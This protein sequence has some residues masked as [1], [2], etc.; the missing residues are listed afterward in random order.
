MGIQNGILDKEKEYLKY[1][2]QK[3]VDGIVLASTTLAME[4]LKELTNHRAP[5]IVLDREIGDS[6]I[7]RIRI[8]DYKGGY[9]ATEHLIKTGYRRLVH[10]AGPEGI[11]SA[12]DRKKGFLDCIRDYDL[13]QERYTI[14]QG[15]FTEECGIKNMELYLRQYGVDE[16]TGLFAAN[17]AMALGALKVINDRKI[18]CPVFQ[19]SLDYC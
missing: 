4:E 5:L 1:L 12:E 7:D 14:I 13:A 17:D 18:N 15:C 2:L 11:S 19:P 8:D 16:P 9:L 6:K 10:F 3:Q